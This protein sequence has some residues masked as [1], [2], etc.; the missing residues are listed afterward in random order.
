MEKKLIIF[1]SSLFAL[2]KRYIV[3]HRFRVYG[4][5]I[6]FFV[7]MSLPK[8]P[9]INL[10]MTKTVIHSVVIVLVVFLFRVPAKIMYVFLMTIIAFSALVSTFSVS[11]V[12]GYLSSISF[13][14]YILMV[15]RLLIDYKE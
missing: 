11:N 8:I 10:F 13:L 3:V 1:E 2:I 4:F 6:L 9:F 5:G 12:H 15:M 7:I 14:V